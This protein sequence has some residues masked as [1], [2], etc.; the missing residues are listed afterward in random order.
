MIKIKVIFDIIF[1]MA[2][3]QVLLHTDKWVDNYADYMYN[4]ALVRI[5]DGNLAKDLVQD[6]FFSGLKSA[7]NFQ[8]KSTERTWLKKS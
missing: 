1:K 5:N 7:K 2:E 8:G 4:Y 6:T 3:K